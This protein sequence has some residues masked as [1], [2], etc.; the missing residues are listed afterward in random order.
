M[1]VQEIQDD[2]RPTDDGVVSANLTLT[3]L[4]NA[5]QKESGYCTALPVSPPLM[6]RM[7]DNLVE[8]FGRRTCKPS[9]LL[10]L[11]RFTTW[12]VHSATEQIR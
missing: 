6:I 12:L 8:I 7:E 10:P 4:V 9:V 11:L 3:T 5:I 2:S 1:F